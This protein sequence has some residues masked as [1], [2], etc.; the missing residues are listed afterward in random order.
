MRAL[1]NWLVRV[2][3]AAATF[4]VP[5]YA[6][7]SRDSAGVLIVENARPAWSDSERLSLAA[8]PRLVIGNN[9]D[10]VYRFRQVRAVMLLTDGRIAVADGGSRQLRL[11]TAQGQFLSRTAVQGTVRG[12]NL[13]MSWV[14]R[15]GGDTIAIDTDFSNVALYSNTGQFVR[16]AALPPW[17]DADPGRRPLLA[18]LLNSGLGVGAPRPGNSTSHP[19]GSRWTDSV[20]L[21]LVTASSDV[22][23]ELGTFPYVEME[24]GTLRP[25]TVWLSSILVFAGDDDRFYVGFGDRYEI[26]VYAGDGKLQSIIRRSWTPTPI[27][28]DDWEHWVVE[29]SKLWVRTTGAERERDVQEVRESPWAEQNPAFSQFIVDRGGRLWVREAH[30][31]DAIGAGSL[32]G[33]PAVPSSWSV[34]DSRGR[35]L[36]DVSMPTGFQPFEIGTDY[37]TGIMRTDGVNQVVI[38]ELSARGR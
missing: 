10:S 36:G 32:A 22:P 7:S 21:Q 5:L 27:T 31:Q 11:F 26:R 15:L 25:T 12:Q 38:Y 19:T 4:A 13:N 28:D 6:Q 34:F 8:K 3:T 29:W 33:I 9:A 23:R 20:R 35:W 1:A 30:W 18:T 17:V 2:A 24:Q 37:V 14:R 16:T